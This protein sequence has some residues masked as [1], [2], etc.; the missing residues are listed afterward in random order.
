V[1]VLKPSGSLFVDLGDK[2]GRPGGGADVNPRTLPGAGKGT[3]LRTRT[4]SDGGGRDKCLML[5]PERYR[6]ACV[7]QLGLIAR[8]VICWHKINGLPESVTDRVRR[9][10]EDWVHLTRQPRY[11]SAVDEIRE[12]QVTVGER[13]G[14]VAGGKYGRAL[15]SERPNRKLDPLGKLPGSVWSI[16]SEPL[17]VPEHLG[18]DH[19]AAFPL[20]WPLRLIAGWSPPGICVE[21]GE[22]RRPV[23]SRIRQTYH[24]N[25]QRRSGAQQVR[26]GA[27]QTG[28]AMDEKWRAT[29]SITGYACACTPYTD[30]PERRGR[31]FLNHGESARS[32][33]TTNSVERNKAY[34]DGRFGP[35]G[36]VR[37][38]HLDAWT[39]PPTRPSVVLD[40]FAGTG[41]TMLAARALGR[42][43][44]GVDRSHDYARLAA[45][46]TTDPGELAKAMRV[47]RPPVQVDGQP[48]LFD[49]AEVS[50]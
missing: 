46:R 34:R 45:W 11:Y 39:P 12:P 18:V 37:E 27:A 50:R 29:A 15:G 7:D 10:H 35:A 3:T 16:P 47:E 44:V 48:A 13:H 23:V 33:R 8:A 25:G 26:D 31:S 17:R 40:P 30:H 6:I 20:E 1:R 36:P 24:G 49:V 4:A 21:C 38:Y 43:G 41:T 32:G 5:L 22:G 28:W 14:I 19:F 42:I 2:Y 9:S